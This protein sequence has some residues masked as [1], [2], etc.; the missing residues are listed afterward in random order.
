MK[1]KESADS[2]SDSKLIHCKRLVCK[3]WVIFIQFY[4]PLLIIWKTGRIFV[5][6]FVIAISL[7]SVDRKR[8]QATQKKITKNLF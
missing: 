8:P 1:K 5:L 6:V 7:F 2:D 4:T 3:F